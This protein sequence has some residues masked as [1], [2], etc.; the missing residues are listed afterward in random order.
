MPVGRCRLCLT[1]NVQLRDS[2]F[3]S[4][5]FYKLARDESRAN[6]KPVLINEE[7]SLLS[8]EQA[9]IFSCVPAL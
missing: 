5:G 7:V 3:M 4:A 8:S 2:H 1:Q 9:S 6:P